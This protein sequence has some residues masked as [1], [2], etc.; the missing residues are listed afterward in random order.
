MGPK[1]QQASAPG[2]GLTFDSFT[3][4]AGS[5]VSWLLT[6]GNRGKRKDLLRSYLG[7][8][9]SALERLDELPR[10]AQEEGESVE[11]LSV[12]WGAHRQA[13]AKRRDE[14][15]RTAFDLTFADWKAADRER[16]DQRWQAFAK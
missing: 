13:I 15:A 8:L 11:A 1:S 6:K 4:Q 5:V 3:L 10:F 9:F 12:R 16:I 2:Y 7:H 14:I